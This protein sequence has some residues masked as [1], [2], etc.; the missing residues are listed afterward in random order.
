MTKPPVPQSFGRLSPDVAGMPLYRAVERDL[1]GA[2]ES[3]R[4]GPGD[5]L[6]SEADLAASFGVSVGT[7]RKAV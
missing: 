3:S 6:P 7:V 5:A 1:L 2:I 4:F